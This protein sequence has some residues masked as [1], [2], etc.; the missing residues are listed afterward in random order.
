M[1][2]NV[3]DGPLD[4]DLLCVLICEGHTAVKVQK[5]ASFNMVHKMCLQQKWTCTVPL[6]ADM[7]FSS[8]PTQAQTVS[9]LMLHIQKGAVNIWILNK[10]EDKYI[11]DTIK[12][13]LLICWKQLCLMWRRL[14]VVFF[15]H[16]CRYICPSCVID[17]DHNKAACT[18]CVLL[19][20]QLNTA[21]KKSV[22]TC[23]EWICHLKNVWRKKKHRYQ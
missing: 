13:T 9:G 4:D 1:S 17:C 5:S 18:C 21:Q 6:A 22:S 12:T 7:S 10:Q 8:Y 23:N 16:S 3:P 11:R 2:D 20:P 15:R 19:I 14:S